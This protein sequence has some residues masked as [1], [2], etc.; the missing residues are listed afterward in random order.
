GTINRASRSFPLDLRASPRYH[1]LVGCCS[2]MT[3]ARLAGLRMQIASTKLLGLLDTDRPPEVRRAAALVLGE[4]GAK[5]A[6]VAKAL[7][8]LL[9]DDR[10][11]GR[12]EAS[13]ALGKLKVAQGIPPRGARA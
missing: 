7:C 1:N 2:R 10:P 6:T 9:N 11:E 4:L 8:E 13:K 5:D 12:L 3:V